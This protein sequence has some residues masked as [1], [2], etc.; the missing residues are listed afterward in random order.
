MTMKRRPL[1]EAAAE[2]DTHSTENIVK[3]ALIAACCFISQ[4]Q[5]RLSEWRVTGSIFGA[6]SYLF[7]Q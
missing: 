4:A 5:L 3:E 6:R 1:T 7:R 2:P